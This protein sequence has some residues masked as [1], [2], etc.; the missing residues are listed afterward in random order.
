M[1]ASQPTLPLARREP[2]AS[3][4]ASSRH[5]AFLRRWQLEHATAR[6]PRRL[7]HEARIGVAGAARCLSALESE[8]RAQ[9]PHDLRAYTWAQ[10]YDA[11]RRAGKLI[12]RVREHARRA[13][14]A[15][16]PLPAPAEPESSPIAAAP[17]EPALFPAAEPSERQFLLLAVT[18]RLPGATVRQLLRAVAALEER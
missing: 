10:V 7:G 18:R 3:I 13:N 6:T 1:T 2:L 9:A 11:L 17:A 12:R 16:S 15:A 5:D 8:W 14:P 4:V